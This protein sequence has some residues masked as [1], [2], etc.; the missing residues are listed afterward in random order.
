M[1]APA[2]TTV[3]SLLKRKKKASLRRGSRCFTKSIVDT[4]ASDVRAELTEDMAAE[5]IATIKKPFNR[6]GT[7]VIMKI[8]KMKSKARI[9]EPGLGSGSGIWNGCWR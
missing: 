6:W 4:E 2:Q 3:E 8:G 1:R 7:S 9:P 5:R